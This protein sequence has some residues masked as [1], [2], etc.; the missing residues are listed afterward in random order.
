MN[1]TAIE[2]TSDLATY[3]RWVQVSPER[4][5]LF[6][7]ALLM[8]RAMVEAVGLYDERFFAYWEDVDYSLRCVQTGYRNIVVPAAEVRHAA[9]TLKIDPSSK[10]VRYYYY[11]TR[12][13]L[14]FSRKHFG[15]WAGRRPLWWAM[16]RLLR[17]AKRLKGDPAITDA[18][19][20][21]L[22]D[23][24]TFRRGAFDPARRLPRPVRRLLLAAN[25]ALFGA[26]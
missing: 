25:R 26:H 6:G 14:L 2:V 20:Y 15:W 11:M 13:E 19:F 10:P 18:I 21:G 3:Y 17:R 7:A 8:R 24:L 4:I 22:F 5:W 12:N 9:G 23:G 1:G 16:R